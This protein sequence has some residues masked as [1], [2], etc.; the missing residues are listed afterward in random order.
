MSSNINQEIDLTQEYDVVI[1]GAGVAGA[2]VAKRIM[3][4]AKKHGECKKVLIVEA[5]R[6]TGMSADKYT[7]HVLEYQGKKAKLPNSPYADNPNAPQP[8][9]TDTRQMVKPDGTV[10]HQVSDV[11]YLVQTGPQP[12]L[13]SYTRALGGTTLHWLGTTLRMLP[14]D[15]KMKTHYGHGVDWPIEYEDLKSYYEQ[16]ET[17]II[18]VAGNV[19]DQDYPN[20]DSCYFG[21]Y[22]YPMERVPPSYLDNYLAGKLDGK[23]INFNGKP[24]AVKVSS[25]PAGRNSTP[26]GNYKPVGAVG[27]ASQGQRCEGNSSC[28]PI[29]PVQAKY[30]ALKTLNALQRDYGVGGKCRNEKGLEVDI[31]AQ[32]VAS[33]I[34]LDAAVQKVSHIECKRYDSESSNNYETIKLRA[35]TFVLAAHAI[36]NAKLLLASK[37]SPSHDLSPC[38]AVANSSDQVGRNLMDHPIILTWGLLPD[39]IGAYRGPGSTSGIPA[40]RDGDFREQHSAFRVEIGNWGWSFPAGAPYST[41]EI[42]LAG[43]DASIPEKPR[44]ENCNSD[45]TVKPL[46]GKAL[47]DK[48]HDVLSRQFR[49]A[50]EFEQIPEAHNRVTIDEQY[51]DQLGNHRPVIHYDLPDYVKAAMPSARNASRKIYQLLNMKPLYEKDTGAPA[52]DPARFQFPGEDKDKGIDYTRYASSAAGYVSYGDQNYAYEGAGH[53]AGTHRMGSSKEDSVVNK[54]QQSWDHKNLFLAGC[55]NM[56]TIGT[57]NP[58]LTMTALALQLGENINKYLRGEK[59]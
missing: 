9:E 13:S 7:S 41:F 18:G 11:G 10:E 20:I 21:N 33:T 48:L 28:I 3:T 5:G 24:L 59:L 50:W 49:V 39:K 38:N 8:N 15:F 32:M 43:Q 44:D 45:A 52:T 23:T 4:D 30:N 26:R 36:E 6:N 12:F 14:N 31:V 29:C 51:K 47:R 57:S 34:H 55:G 25:T 54:H 37:K 27:N 17:E 53:V 42:L 56:P 40:F 58:T 19:E 22:N 1:V 16:A 46:W 35:K 2:A